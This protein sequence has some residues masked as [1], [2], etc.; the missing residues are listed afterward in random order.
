MKGSHFRI[1]N[2]L[3]HQ[4]SKNPLLNTLGDDEGPKM[5]EILHI[6][7]KNTVQ[8]LKYG[9][10]FKEFLDPR[11]QVLEHTFDFEVKMETEE[12][13]QSTFEQ[14]KRKTLKEIFVHIQDFL[15]ESASNTVSVAFN[16]LNN[17]DLMDKEAK[18][19]SANNL[20]LNLHSIFS[21]V[22]TALKN[23]DFLKRAIREA[24]LD[25]EEAWNEI[26]Y[27]LAIK[28]ENIYNNIL[29]NLADL[30]PQAQ[31]TGGTP[32]MREVLKEINKMEEEENDLIYANN[33]RIKDYINE[34]GDYTRFIME[35]INKSIQ[36]TQSSEGDSKKRTEMEVFTQFSEQLFW[37]SQQKDQVLKNKYINEFFS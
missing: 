14:V 9:S 18:N 12:F 26:Y 8:K 30:Y 36:V 28:A 4:L 34:G 2:T 17:D 25:E 1:K 6:T 23:S 32:R 37:L 27:L 13:N 29:A 16:F 10:A 20:M 11:D 3:H 35:V 15:V 19:Y 5:E 7:N 21:E 33:I 31:P 22:C 24:L